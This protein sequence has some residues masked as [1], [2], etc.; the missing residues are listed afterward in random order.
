MNFF[1]NFLNRT[2]LISDWVKQRKWT[3]G[4][5]TIGSLIAYNFDVHN[6]IESIKVIDNSKNTTTNHIT[7]IITNYIIQNA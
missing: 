3:I 5:F 4:T 2:R 7:N 1:F 6:H